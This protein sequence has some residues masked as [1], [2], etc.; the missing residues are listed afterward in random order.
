MFEGRRKKKKIGFGDNVDYERIACQNPFRKNVMKKVI[1]DILKNLFYLRG[2]IQDHYSKVIEHYYDLEK[3]KIKDKFSKVKRNDRQVFNFGREASR[4][5]S[6]ISRLM[7]TIYPKKMDNNLLYLGVFI[8][9]SI[10]FPKESYFFRFFY[11]NKEEEQKE[12]EIKNENTSKIIRKIIFA[13]QNHY[14]SKMVASKVHFLFLV[15]NQVTKTENLQI[16]GFSPFLKKKFSRKNKHFVFID[17]VPQEKL[18]QEKDWKESFIKF[19]EN[20]FFET[21]E[22]SA[23]YLQEYGWYKWNGKIKGIHSILE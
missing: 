18:P 21:K 20:N 15:P 12:N 10:T 17:L 6:D 11:E 13:L 19:M 23:F 9:S 1:E 5:F 22:N 7:D 2:Q 14:N 4:L 3:N 16:D 8:G